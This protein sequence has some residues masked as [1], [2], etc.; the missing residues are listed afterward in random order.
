MSDTE[1]VWTITQESC[2]D[3]VVIPWCGLL[4]SLEACLAEIEED[5]KACYD[6]HEETPPIVRRTELNLKWGDET[7][8]HVYSVGDDYFYCTRHK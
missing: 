5:M 3:P 4:P 1:Q 8:T 2:N 7:K 6:G